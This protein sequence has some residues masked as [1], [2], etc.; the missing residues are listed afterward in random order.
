MTEEVLILKHKKKRFSTVHQEKV[1][2]IRFLN[3]VEV[4][5]K[6]TKIFKKHIG[7]RNAVNFIDLFELVYGIAPDMVEDYKRFYYW[8]LVVKAAKYLRRSNK[9]FVII[10]RGSMFVLQTREESDFYKDIMDMNIKS[11]ENAKIR[12][13]EWVKKE[14]WKNF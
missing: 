2:E 11:M 10:K 1:G 12:A 4:I 14:K 6:L 3:N 7:E 8:E 13:D 9:V 5:E